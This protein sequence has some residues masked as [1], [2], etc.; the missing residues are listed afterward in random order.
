M[1][2][3]KTKIDERGREKKGIGSS[4]HSAEHEELKELGSGV[5]LVH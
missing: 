5:Q 1:R 3:V 4:R 2:F